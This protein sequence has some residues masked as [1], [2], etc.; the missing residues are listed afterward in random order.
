[1][2]HPQN[3]LPDIENER[4]IVETIRRIKL[5]AANGE[6]GAGSG[7]T[8]NGNSGPGTLETLTDVSITPVDGELIY[9]SGAD[10]IALDIPADWATQRYALG[11]AAGFPAWVP[12]ADGVLAI[13]WGF[14]W[15]NNYSGS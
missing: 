3:R 7:N 2:A 4:I 6:L 5:M 10:W 13:G 8:G 15:G 9:R 12:T 14:N 11:I 1:M